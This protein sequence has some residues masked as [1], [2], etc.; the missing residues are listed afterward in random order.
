MP[1]QKPLE[2][3]KDKVPGLA[4]RPESVAEGKRDRSW[5]EANR[6][7]SFRIREVDAERLAELAQELKV[8]R[9]ALTRALIEL[10]L[11]AVDAGRVE[12]KTDERTRETKDRLGRFR[13]S[14]RRFVLASWT[15]E[16]NGKTGE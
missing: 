12:F 10:A 4:K 14:T 8:S 1:R 6:A 7:F 3:V 15:G 13:L 5:D 2:D 9:D 16:R 11:D